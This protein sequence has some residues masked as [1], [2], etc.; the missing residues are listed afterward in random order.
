LRAGDVD[1]ARVDPSADWCVQR[2][3]N[4]RALAAAIVVLVSCGAARATA[5]PPAVVLAD[6]D[7]GNDDVVAPPGPI[8]DCEAKLRAAGVTFAPAALPVKVGRGRQ[9]TCGVG[10]AVSYRRGPAKLRYN[11][12]PVMSCGMALALA[13]FEQVVAEEA[14]RHLG[15]RVIRVQHGGTYNCR[16]M[17]RF[18]L[19]SE[20]SYGNA[21]DIRS[22]TL[23][24]GRTLPVVSTFG[25]T[26]APPTTPAAHFWRAVASRLYD[27]GTFSV[28]LTPFFDRQHADHL[29]L[30]LA[31][32]RVDGTR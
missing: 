14:R 11:G 13:R 9:P 1:A 15:R 29:H 18:D 30:D 6:V 27:E 17:A 4:A 26:D 32:Y 28:V 8:A 10:Q 22:V 24:G 5:S 23:Q 19:V 7:P 12:A 25:A 21:I 16:K 31:R 20:H 3:M 2:T